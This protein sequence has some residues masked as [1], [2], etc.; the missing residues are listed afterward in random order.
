MSS[1]EE[2]RRENLVFL[3]KNPRGPPRF[4]EFAFSRVDF[5]IEKNV[6][7]GLRICRPYTPPY[8]ILPEIL[9]LGA[10]REGRVHMQQSL[11]CP[12]TRRGEQNKSAE[13]VRY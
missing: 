6:M 13:S 11:L 4:R 3:F 9:L 7:W 2:L 1:R 12:V 5:S 10:E 8:G